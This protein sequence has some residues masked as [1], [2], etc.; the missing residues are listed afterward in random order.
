MT[1]K[2][3]CAECIDR[4]R[5]KLPLKRHLRPAWIV[6]LQRPHTLPPFSH[7]LRNNH[8]FLFSLIPRLSN[9]DALCWWLSRIQENVFVLVEHI[10]APFYLWRTIQSNRQNRRRWRYLLISDS[11]VYFL[12]GDF[13]TVPFFVKD[14][15]SRMLWTPLSVSSPILSIYG[16]P[17]GPVVCWN[18]SNFAT[19]TQK[20]G[21]YL[22]QIGAAVIWIQLL[23]EGI[24]SFIFGLIYAP[25]Y[26]KMNMTVSYKMNMEDGQKAQ[27][28]S[29]SVLNFEHKRAL[30]SSCILHFWAPLGLSAWR[31]KPSDT[32]VAVMC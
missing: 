7:F 15:G 4:Y 11:V 29:G 14:V 21:H 28:R 1:F 27:S 9:I 3:S 24:Q 32:E 25:L 8:S 20:L 10:I 23:F 16:P 2:V 12:S 5:R 13:S 17:T 6:R 18:Y 22:F 30:K 19:Q 26:T 31:K